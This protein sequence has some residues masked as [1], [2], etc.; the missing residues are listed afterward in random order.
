MCCFSR[1]YKTRLTI[2]LFW[3]R[4]ALTSFTCIELLRKAIAN[5]FGC[6]CVCV[7]CFCFSHSFVK[8]H[9]VLCVL[10][11]DAYEI[12]LQ[13]VF[14]F[15]PV[16]RL[17]PYTHLCYAHT[18]NINFNWTELNW[19]ESD[20]LDTMWILT[21]KRHRPCPHLIASFGGAKASNRHHQLNSNEEIIIIYSARAKQTQSTSFLIIWIALQ[22]YLRSQVGNVPRIPMSTITGFFSSGLRCCF[23]LFSFLIIITIFH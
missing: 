10:C 13:H 23:L 19:S 11:V 18:T 14:L 9:C 3:M 22:L 6:A 20:W 5:L 1:V 16:L 15:V 7:F 17:V 21:T 4:I 8:E 12:C 2:F